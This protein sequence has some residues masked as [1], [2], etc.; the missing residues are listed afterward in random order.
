MTNSPPLLSVV[1]TSRNDDHGGNALHRTQLFVTGVLEQ[2]SRYNLD[3]ELIIVEWNPP[4]DRPKLAQVLKWSTKAGPCSVRIIEVPSAVHGRFDHSDRLPL[5]QMIAKNVGIR[6]AQGRFIL[7]TN[8]D[9]L[10]SNEVVQFLASN[11]LM[12]GRLY[13]V[14]RYDVPPDIPEG[15]SIEEQL[16][17]SHE[18]IIRIHR[19]DGTR[20]L[21]NP[22]FNLRRLAES[23][24]YHLRRIK[25][26]MKL[27]VHLLHTN[28]CGDFT[29]MAREHWF[30]VRGY[31]EFNMYS[32]LLDGLLCYAA[33]HAGARE[34]VM[35]DPMRVY[36]IEHLPG[37]G[38]SP[39]LG[40]KLLRK[41]LVDAG[42]PELSARQYTAW[43]R[44]MSREHQ[45]IIFNQTD[46]WGLADE[47]LTETVAA[48]GVDR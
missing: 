29:L 43:V 33:H 7:A 21:E 47:N 31:A 12:S 27:G 16:T 19:R 36:H 8:M 2:A 17:Y 25:R 11:Q 9:I 18:N 48:R 5:F 15:V 38:W 40:S 35:G 10:F 14:D 24:D 1:V 34:T 42:I 37:S 22:G 46:G 4:P 23:F 44:Q 41:R 32:F 28:A 3:A 20:I 6:R 45:P 26:F 39:G 13:R 30:V